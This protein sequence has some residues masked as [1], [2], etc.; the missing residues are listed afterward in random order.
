MGS[1]RGP[2][3]ALLAPPRIEVNLPPSGSPPRASIMSMMG[4]VWA[5]NPP[6]STTQRQH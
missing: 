2:E 6:I 1:G 5:V 4:F 3:T